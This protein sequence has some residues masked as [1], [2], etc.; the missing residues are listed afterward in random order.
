MR[1]ATSAKHAEHL[2]NVR[3]CL[4]IAGLEAPVSNRLKAQACNEPCCRL[5]GIADPE[6][7]MVK[8]LVF[9]HQRCTLRGLGLLRVWNSIVARAP[10]SPRCAYNMHQP[11]GM[12]CVKL[13]NMRTRFTYLDSCG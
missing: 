9:T 5:L 7:K 1:E 2:Y 3:H 8:P 12:Q 13:L 6:L 11:C 10:P 4:T